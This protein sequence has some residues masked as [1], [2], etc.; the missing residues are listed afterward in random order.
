MELASSNQGTLG[1]QAKPV[2]RHTGERARSTEG[3]TS[4]WPV[5]HSECF[6]HEYY[7]LSFRVVNLGLFKMA[8]SKDQS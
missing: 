5:S 3:T 2:V 6:A 4:V 7:K 8:R 1:F